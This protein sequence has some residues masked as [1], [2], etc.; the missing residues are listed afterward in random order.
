VT[1]FKALRKQSKTLHLHKQLPA[2]S[3][4]DIGSFRHF[5]IDE[6]IKKKSKRIKREKAFA[7]KMSL[8]YFF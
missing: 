8:I 7:T 1:R 5:S 3:E 4:M 2:R 6:R